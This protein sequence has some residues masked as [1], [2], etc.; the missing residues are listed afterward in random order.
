MVL[1]VQRATMKPE[2]QYLVIT[3]YYLVICRLDHRTGLNLILTRLLQQNLQRLRALD[4]QE[5]HL[6]RLRHS[7]TDPFP[8]L[9][10]ADGYN[11]PS[12]GREHKR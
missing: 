9:L 11:P 10:P 2:L 12:Q 1:V 4:V 5:L 7:R 3:S 6:R 8:L